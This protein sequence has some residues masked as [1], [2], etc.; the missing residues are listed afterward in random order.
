MRRSAFT[1]IELL[2]VIAIIAILAAILFPVFAQAKLA[3]K[4]TSDLSNVKQI[5]LGFVLYANDNDDA[6]MVQ[7]HDAG[8]L[9][10]DALQPYLKSSDIFRT[11][12]YTR[13]AINTGTELVT[14]ES[15]YVLNGLYGHGETLTANSEPVQQIVFAMRNPE[16]EEI[17]Y[18]AW[19]DNPTDSYDDATLYSEFLDSIYLRPWG[20]GQNFGFLD[21]HVKF[22]VWE[23][24]LQGGQ[25]YP[26]MHNIDRIGHWD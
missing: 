16:S 8:F 14:P 1:L 18:H 5:S 4:K 3:A 15:D 13:K 23:R 6:S 12:A 10:Y 22:T 24:S 9:W 26:G 20:K 25:G 21:G 19:P 17:D 11:P 7:D 2:V